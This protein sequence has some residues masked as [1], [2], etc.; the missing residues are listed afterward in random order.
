MA[1]DMDYI[2]Q[3]HSLYYSKYRLTQCNILPSTDRAKLDAPVPAQD[4]PGEGAGRRRPHHGP[5]PGAAPHL[6]LPGD[7][8]HGRHGLP[9]PAHHEAEDRL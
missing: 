2:A 1:L 3:V 4:P 6:R 7:G 9:E 5:L 8:V